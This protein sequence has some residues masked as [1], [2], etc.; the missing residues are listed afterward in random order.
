MTWATSGVTAKTE[1]EIPISFIRVRFDQ[2]FS[3]LA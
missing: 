1:S 3:Y 2:K